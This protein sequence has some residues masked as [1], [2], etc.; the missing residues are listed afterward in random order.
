MTS[1]SALFFW[2][3]YGCWLPSISSRPWTARSAPISNEPLDLAAY[4]R[5]LINSFRRHAGGAL[6]AATVV[7]LELHHPSRSQDHG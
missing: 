4:P 1:F 2:P 3:A 6:Q 5:P 7:L